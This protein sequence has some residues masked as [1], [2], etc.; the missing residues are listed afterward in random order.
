MSLIIFFTSPLIHK[1]LTLDKYTIHAK[2]T[3]GAEIGDI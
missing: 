3:L 2:I 1:R